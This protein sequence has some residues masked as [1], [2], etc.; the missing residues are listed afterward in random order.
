MPRP[1]HPPWPP[2][3][4]FYR[5]VWGETLRLQAAQEEE[6]RERVRTVAR[7][8]EMRADLSK[9]RA[10][11]Q[12]EAAAERAMQSRLLLVCSALAMLGV[13]IFCVGVVVP[14][15]THI[16]WWYQVELWLRSTRHGSAH[17]VVTTVEESHRPNPSWRRAIRSWLAGRG[18]AREL[19]PSAE[20]VNETDYED[21][22]RAKHVAT[23]GVSSSPRP[24][25][26][27]KRAV[28]LVVA[29]DEPA[30]PP[31]QTDADAEAA[32]ATSDDDAPPSRAVVVDAQSR[33]ANP[34]KMVINMRD[35]VIS[36][37]QRRREGSS[38]PPP[39]TDVEWD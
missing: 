11:E 13:V 38:A 14:N 17:G 31:S 10:R 12:K 39:P 1:E 19:L 32:E 9:K 21:T 27:S 3:K 16:P 30:E 37:K 33:S 7:E 23:F 6:E 28:R 2:I 36:S 15:A 22:T 20:P 34:K 25:V 5:D 18:G 24:H 35:H 4:S 26:A 29:D 8:A